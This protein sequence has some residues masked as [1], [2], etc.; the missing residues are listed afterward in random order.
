MNNPKYLSITYLA[1][2]ANKERIER[3]YECELENPP[4]RMATISIPHDNS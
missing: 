1:T 2:P 3:F 4:I